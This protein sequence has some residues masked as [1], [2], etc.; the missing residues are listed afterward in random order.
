MRDLTHELAT[1]RPPRILIVRLSAVGDVI[2]TMPVINA[3]RAAMPDA[4][5]G[6]V[7]EQRAA[8]L[9]EGHPALDHLI[10]LP[11]GWMK[12]PRIVLGLRRRLRALRFDITVDPQSLTKSA[13]VAWLSGARRRIGF[14]DDK[15]RELSQYLNTELV[16]TELDHVVD[17]HL[18]LLRPLGVARPKVEFRVPEKPEDRT[19]ADAVVRQHG[20]ESGY[21]VINVG[22]GWP[23]RIWP[24]DRFGRVARHLG[25]RHG[26]ASL[27][28]WAG[29]KERDLAEQTVSSS[30]GYAVLAPPTSLAQL[31][32][33]LR[34]AVLCLSGDT[35]PL[36]LAVAVGTRCVSLHGPTW[37]KRSGPYGPGHIA[38]QQAALD[39]GLDRRRKRCS[40]W[41]M[42]AI[43]VERVCEACDQLLDQPGRHAAA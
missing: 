30:G 31:A 40:A 21:A 26:L 22:A 8:P 1:G 14:G 10:V 9:L 34:R 35:G 12:S 25:E 33:L 24:A 2:L 6:W 23:S 37:A 39:S 38:V 16:S 41:L 36:H 29:P 15:G 17:C 27:V 7:V 32:T 19:A 28:V 20:L 13:L 4:V 18:A 11:R 3:L 5:L 42:E 43:T